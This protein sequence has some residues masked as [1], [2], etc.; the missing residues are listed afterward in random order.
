MGYFRVAKFSQCCLENMGINFRKLDDAKI[1]CFT[2]YDVKSAK[3]K[4]TMVNKITV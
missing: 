3:Q 4:Q 2:V 1:S